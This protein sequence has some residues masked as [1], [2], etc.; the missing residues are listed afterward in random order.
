MTSWIYDEKFPTGMQFMF[1]MSSF[2]AAHNDNLEHPAQ[3]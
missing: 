3:Q 1:G 2:P